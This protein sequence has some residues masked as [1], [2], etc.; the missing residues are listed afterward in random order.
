[1][2]VLVGYEKEAYLQNEKIVKQSII[3]QLD[4]TELV[5]VG[6]DEVVI[7]HVVFNN[8]AHFLIGI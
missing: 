8:I 6:I 7:P 3:E 1:M 4:Y 5:V 2:D